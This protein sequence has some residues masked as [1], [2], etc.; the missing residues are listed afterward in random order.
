MD[1][2]FCSNNANAFT[3]L[4]STIKFAT[5]LA[6]GANALFVKE[7]I[8]P[9]SSLVESSESGAAADPANR[10]SVVQL[11]GAEVST[12]R[13]KAMTA[14][15][16]RKHVCDTWASNYRVMDDLNLF[17][18]YC[19]L[20]FVLPVYVVCGALSCLRAFPQSTESD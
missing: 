1:S 18:L 16:S 6:A 17:L 4:Y 19:E 2:L 10:V 5:I 20:K 12:M 14:S 3:R 7:E 8:G 13:A 15:V 11:K 9:D